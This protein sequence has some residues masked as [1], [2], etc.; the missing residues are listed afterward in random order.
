MCFIKDINFNYLNRCNI[1]SILDKDM[2][3]IKVLIK[4]SVNKIFFKKYSYYSPFQD[5]KYIKGKLNISPLRIRLIDRCNSEDYTLQIDEG[6]HSFRNTEVARNS[7]LSNDLEA[8]LC[9]CIIPKGSTIVMNNS[10]V[11]SNQIIFIEELKNN[12]KRRSC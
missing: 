7:Y 5:Y 12:D 10:E 2:F 8:V 6:F 1:T 3:V 4:K 11:V 9:R